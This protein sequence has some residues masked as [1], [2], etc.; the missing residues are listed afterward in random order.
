MELSVLIRGGN[1]PSSI[2]HVI[3][4]LMESDE[5][6]TLSG[7]RPLPRQLLSPQCHSKTLM[8]LEDPGKPSKTF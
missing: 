7:V 6:P 3:D 5:L 2:D 1:L 4:A 8:F